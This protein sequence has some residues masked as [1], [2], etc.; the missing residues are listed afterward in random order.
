MAKRSAARSAKIA[1]A[2]V[3]EAELMDDLDKIMAKDA[4]TRV[5]ELK[6]DQDA[7]RV[8]ADLAKVR[9]T[10]KPRKRS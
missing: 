3:K 1:A 9:K 8:R 7:A 6:R 5:A 2:R 4:K 10:I